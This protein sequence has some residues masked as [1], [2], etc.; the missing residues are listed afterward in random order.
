MMYNIYLLDKLMLAN[1]LLCSILTHINLKLTW[2]NLD[3]KL[4]SI[5]FEDKFRL[6]F[7][8]S[9]LDPKFNILLKI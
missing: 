8:S 6:Y 4:D 7:D 2:T 9:Q 5:S 1:D 3:L